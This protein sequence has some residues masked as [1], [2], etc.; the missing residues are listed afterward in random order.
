MKTCNNNT[1]DIQNTYIAN[2]Q[3]YIIIIPYDDMN[4]PIHLK[5]CLVNLQI[6]SS[7]NCRQIKELYV[8]E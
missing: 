1:C 4:G 6:L 8:T 7:L 3:Q 5:I 2:H